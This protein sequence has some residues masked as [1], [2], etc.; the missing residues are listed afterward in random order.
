M[1]RGVSLDDLKQELK[2]LEAF[3]ETRRAKNLRAFIENELIKKEKE[4]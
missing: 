3:N 4:S 1:E 2:V